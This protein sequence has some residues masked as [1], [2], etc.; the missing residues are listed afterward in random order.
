MTNIPNRDHVWWFEDSMMALEP[1]KPLFSP[2]EK[3][4]SFDLGPNIQIDTTKTLMVSI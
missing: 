3:V 2:T 4:S 1:W